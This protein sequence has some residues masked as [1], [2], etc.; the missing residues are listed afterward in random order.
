MTVE[1]VVNHLKVHE[2]RYRCYKNKGEEKFLLLTHEE[3]LAW[4]KKKDVIDSYF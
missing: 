4:T 3:L 2:E 1:E